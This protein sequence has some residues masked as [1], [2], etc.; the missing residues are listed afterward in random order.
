MTMNLRKIPP[1]KETGKCAPGAFPKRPAV[2]VAAVLLAA[3]VFLFSTGFAKAGDYAQGNAGYLRSATYYSDD[4]VVNFWNSESKNMDAELARIASD[5]FNSIILAVPWREFQPD[6]SPRRYN[7]YA[8]EKLDK[9]MDAAGNLGLGVMLRV[10][11]TWDYYGRD[12]VLERYKA[13]MYDGEIRQAWLEYV[14]RLYTRAS[15]HDSFCGGFLTWEDFWNFTDTAAGLGNGG[16]GIDLAKQCGY[17]D[18][19]RRA[20]SLEEL[21]ALY[22]H[23]ISDYGR[24]YFPSEK[25]P[26]R[27]VFYGFYDEFLN[28]LLADSQTRF[29]DLSME[30]RLDGDPVK[31]GDGGHEFYVHKATFPCGGSAFTSTMFGIPM[32]CENNYEQVTAAQALPNIPAFLNLLHTYNGGKPVYIDQF[33]FT[34]NTEGFEHNARLYEAE[35]AAY[36]E[37]AAPVLRSM[38]MGYGI[39]TYRDY[40]DNKLYNAQFALGRQ[41]WDFSGGSSVMERNGGNEAVLPGGGR[42]YQEI[43]NRSTGNMGRNVTVRFLLE[44]ERDCSVTV[45]VAGQS[46]AVKAGEPQMVELTFEKCKPTGL[47][48]SCS[49]A[50]PAYVDDVS[51]FTCVTE[52]DLY[53]MD[54]SEGPCIGAVRSL[55]A[56]LQ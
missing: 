25:S 30:V 39:W 34:D 53:C 47:T 40:G 20:Y 27:A 18:Y 29:P 42:I 49:G 11:Y 17:Q 22:G 3:S 21:E 13:L 37:G 55:N 43:G 4:W 41:G 51:V 35:K 12:S 31:T 54:G 5:G 2:T 1:A 26:A 16:P 28:E 7:S 19:A 6:T 36:L 44:G 32:G 48:I 14:E 52:G 9:V 50:G 45:T 24:L 10:G 56:Q 46:Q 8:W 15:A 23:A 33:L 38:T